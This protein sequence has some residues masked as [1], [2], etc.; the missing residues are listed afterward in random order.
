MKS[1]KD[2]T[3]EELWELFPIVLVP[4]RECWK[5]WFREEKVFLQ[6][7]F[8][9][10]VI[11]HIGSTAVPGIMAKPTVDILM[12]FPSTEEMRLAAEV[13]ESH[14]YLCMSKSEN[15]ISLNKGYTASG[16]AEKV[17]HF[18]LRM[19]GD[20]AEIHFRDYLNAHPEV[21]K[22]Y[23]RLK[24]S[25][26]KQYEHDRDGYTEAKSDFINRWTKEAEWKNAERNR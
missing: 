19:A 6:Q 1:L 14:G 24:L 5:D 22:E 10:A 12:E 21:A 15:R 4:H 8:P 18:H 20:H 16:Y 7:L 17:F 13:M 23:E 26:W 3:L 9:R 11:S 25:L 2:M